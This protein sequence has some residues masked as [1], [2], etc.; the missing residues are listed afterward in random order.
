MA[1]MNTMAVAQSFGTEFRFIWPAGTDPSLVDPALLLGRRFTAR[2]E[3][4]E[5][6]I[7]DRPVVYERDLVGLDRQEVQ[8][9]LA[10]LDGP[11]FVE[12][13]D[14]FGIVQFMDDDPGEAAK[15]FRACFRAMEWSDDARRLID[16]TSALGMT[17]DVC[18]LHIRAGDIVSGDWRH[19][20]YYGKYMPLPFVMHAIERLS[21]GGERRVLLISDNDPLL[22]WLRSRFPTVSTMTDLIPDYGGLPEMLRA[23]ADVLVLSRSGSMY[24]PSASAFSSFAAHIGGHA[25]TPA[26]RLVPTGREADVLYEGV[27]RTETDAGDLPF[28]RPLVAHD[29]VWYLDVFGDDLP[30]GEQRDLARRAVALAPDF[31]GA[32]TRLA[33]SA[34][35]MGDRRAAAAAAATA[36]GIGRTVK[37]SPDAP[38]EAFATQVVV[39]CFE[40]VLGPGRRGPHRRLLRRL[41][42]GSAAARQRTALVSAVDSLPETLRH[43]SDMELNELNREAIVG[44]LRDLVGM[45]EWISGADEATLVAL[46]RRS[47]SWEGAAVEIGRFREPT[48]GAHY[49]DG[50]FQALVRQVERAVV[51]L[52]QAV[53]TCL[54]PVRLDEQAPVRGRAGRTTE[55]PTGLHW[56]EGWVV[57]QAESQGRLIG[58]LA[59]ASATGF[60]GAAAASVTLP[61]FEAL[62]GPTGGA[63]TGYRMP[64][65]HEMDCAASPGT[66]PTV[67]GV[68]RDGRASR[69]HVD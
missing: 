11:V 27:R 40:L 55:S 44:L 53:G 66:G 49:G 61:D 68:A 34:A 7:G 54:Q 16:V 57:E 33:L 43:L 15:R 52:S 64:V 56:L 2:F 26:D 60:L 4:A 30:I 63:A 38:F 59:L 28:L 36:V 65:T 48:M 29:I 6:D 23:F 18:A 25:V 47:V 32:H 42:R 17:E 14:P 31:M 8:T 46:R 3:M 21:R 13:K 39:A 35:L 10:G 69:L 41:L 12:I 58:G 5:E 20:M 51:H 67:F 22:R 1:L 62:V 19:T 50:V 9:R 37:G 24:G 45:V